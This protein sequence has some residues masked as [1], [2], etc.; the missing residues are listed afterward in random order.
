[1]AV[2]DL[3]E[4]R[5]R[6]E[7]HLPGQDLGP[8]WTYS[9][10]GRSRPSTWS[11]DSRRIPARSRPTGA[12]DLAAVEDVEDPRI[13][14]LGDHDRAAPGC[15]GGDERA[16]RLVAPRRDMD[17]VELGDPRSTGRTTPPVEL[18]RWP[19][20]SPAGRRVA[21]APP[22]VALSPTSRSPPAAGARGRARPPWTG[23]C[24]VRTTGAGRRG[25]RRATVSPARRRRCRCPGRD[26]RRPRRGFVERLGDRGPTDGQPDGEGRSGS[27]RQPPGS[28]PA[29][30][31]WRRA[32]ARRR[33]GDP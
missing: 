25:C 5:S 17:L 29:S 30:T 15:R 22:Q 26:R 18:T 1:M 19:G 31:R 32:W 8:A 7:R 3:G 27:R 20:A 11:S 16:N 21:A 6:G 4:A 12:A 13:A 10:A 24:P 9:A 28:R 33:G 14:V 2:D 23:R